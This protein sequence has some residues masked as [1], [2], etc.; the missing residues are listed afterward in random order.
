[1]SERID[2]FCKSLAEKLNNVEGRMN[3]LKTRVESAPKEAQDALRKQLDAA[4]RKITAQKQAIEKARTNA[5][6]W[7]EQKK[8]EAGAAVD[9]WKAN[10]EA[11]KL[12]ARADRAE[13]FAASE[14]EI[15]A[16]TIDDAEQAVL[17]AV[18][19]R[20]DAD[21]VGVK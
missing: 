6:N 14:I 17:E 9:Q 3:N 5:G 7:I 13:E 10:R 8:S 19:A 4:Q 11:N 15:A 18:I 20:M 1:M 12:A 21:A 2:N 16:A